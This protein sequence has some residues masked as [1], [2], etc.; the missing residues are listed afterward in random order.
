MLRI[1]QLP[2]L[3]FV[4]YKVLGTAIQKLI[5]GLLYPLFAI[6]IE[7]IAT[8]FNFMVGLVGFIFQLT[9][10]NYLI[11]WMEKR[12]FGKAIIKGI[13]SFIKAFGNIFDFINSGFKIVGVDPKHALIIYSIKLN[14][15]LERIINKHS[16]ARDRLCSRRLIHLTSR[17]MIISKR[18]ARKQDKKEGLHKKAKR[19]FDEKVLK[20]K[21]WKQRREIRK[22]GRK[23]DTKSRSSRFCEKRDRKRQNGKIKNITKQHSSRRRKV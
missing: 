22:E 10:L 20:K 13:T 14:R 21:T 8:G 11:D 4:W 12:P 19:L 18:N 3:Y 5:Y 17:E 2:I 7:Y 1:V 15:W 6:F 16:N 9:L 23:R